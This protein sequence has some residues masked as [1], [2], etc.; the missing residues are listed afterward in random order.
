MA[1]R[2]G[3]ELDAVPG[4]LRQ[5]R[6]ERLCTGDGVAE[7][8]QLFELAD[9]SPGLLVQTGVLDRASHE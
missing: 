5:E 2:C 4:D 3:Q 6:V 1:G 7:V 9:P 8:R